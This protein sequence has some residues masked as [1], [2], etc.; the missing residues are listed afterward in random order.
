MKS[1]TC[2]K[3]IHGNLEINNSNLKI[4]Y[5]KGKYVLD[6]LKFFGSISLISLFVDKLKNYNNII[7]V[8]ENAKFWIFAIASVYLVY[9]FFEFIIRKK[10]INRLEINNIS[11]IKIED[12]EDYKEPD[13]DSKIEITF[14]TN[15]SL[16]KKIELQKQNNQLPEFLEELK[17]RNT[18]ILIVNK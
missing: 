4:K 1:K 18:R 3:I 9:L 5:R 13:E 14:Y 10:W 7:G 16:N 8:Y 17:K 15:S 12:E 2:F 6:T 11:K